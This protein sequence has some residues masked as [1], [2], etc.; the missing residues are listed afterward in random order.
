MEA[1]LGAQDQVLANVKQ[2]HAQKVDDNTLG[3]VQDS[4]IER[5]LGVTVAAV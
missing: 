4:W 5:N 2:K 1:R 3:K